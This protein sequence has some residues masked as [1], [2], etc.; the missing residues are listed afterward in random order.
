MFDVVGIGENSIDYV[1]ELPVYP[2]L[3]GPTAKT[4]IDTRRVSPGG[5]VA[6]TLCTCAAMGLSTSYV[7]ALGNDDG[8]RLVRDELTKRGVDLSHSTTRDAPNRYAVILVDKMTGERVVLWQRDSSLELHARD[9]NPGVIRSARLLHVDDLDIEASIQAARIAREGGLP[10][11]SDIG[12][13]TYG[14]HLLIAELTDAVTVPIFAEGGPEALTGED[15]PERALRALQQPHH[16]FVCVT[17]GARGAM[18]LEGNTVHTEPGV[19]VQ[20]VDTTS[21]GDVFRGAFIYA[22]LRGDAPREIL[23]FAN[24]AAALSCTKVGAMSSVPTLADVQRLKTF[25]SS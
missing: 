10:V 17:L 12:H 22:L 2:Q 11:T 7:G 4:R 25:S 14:T 8:G 24:A 5:Q 16:R 1:Y 15:D 21:A 20:A 6:T 3:R 23:R 18:M 9:I 13:A 19:R